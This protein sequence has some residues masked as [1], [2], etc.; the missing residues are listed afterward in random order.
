MFLLRVIRKNIYLKENKN[1]VFKTELFHFG[2]PNYKLEQLGKKIIKVDKYFPS[3]KK[4]YCCSNIH[5]LTLETRVYDCECGN[6]I[7]W[8]I[9]SALN[10]A[11]EG[12]RILAEQTI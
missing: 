4:C 2:V 8:D 1:S 6:H 10:L 12:I 9:N 7:D 3:S 5:N 11:I